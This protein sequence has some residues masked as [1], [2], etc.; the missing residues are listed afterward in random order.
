MPIVDG[1]NS[2][3]IVTPVPDVPPVEPVPTLTVLSPKASDI[4]VDTRWTPAMS[5]MSH[6]SGSKWVVD[7]YSQVIDQDSQ[8]SGQQQSLNPVYQQYNKVKNLVIKVASALA[9]NQDPDTKVMTLSG[10]GHIFGNIKPNEG[11]MFVADIGNGQKASFRVTSSILK[12]VLKDQVFEISYGLSHVDDSAL[13][14]LENKTI[15]TSVFREDFITYGQNPVIVEEDSIVLSKL[16]QVYDVVCKQFFGRFFSKEFS[17][18]LLPGQ[19]YSIY[20]P[21]YVDFISKVFSHEDH[22]AILKVKKISMGLDDVYE[23]SNFWQALLNRDSSYLNIGFKKV[24]LAGRSLFQ[25]NPYVSPFR[26]AGIDFALYP[27]DPEQNIGDPDIINSIRYS[28]NMLSGAY[29]VLGYYGAED[30]Q[31]TPY[32]AT[33][34]GDPLTFN[35]V[36]MTPSPAGNTTTVQR[37]DN[38]VNAPTSSLPAMY[39]VLH[40]EYYVFTANFYNKTN[41]QSV[42]EDMVNQYI[43]GRP[44]DMVSLYNTVQRYATWG[45]LEQYYYVPILLCIIKG[46]IRGYQ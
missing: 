1:R 13:A 33:V 42:I 6:I 40:D 2:S 41:T 23:Q 16:E 30:Y 9:T 45:V 11:D 43:S 29:P 12:S 21:F 35:S 15:K 46:V 18:Y 32:S 38:L 31:L 19:D 34:S 22:P 4:V 36:G 17:T 25:L 20:D 39:P 7:Y 3:G 27:L 5:L 14:D 28:L 10:S 8:L 44:I 26:Y 37:S 24:G